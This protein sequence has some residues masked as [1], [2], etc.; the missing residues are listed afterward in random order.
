MDLVEN[1][2]FFHTLNIGKIA[3]QNVLENVL[4]RKISFLDYKKIKLK[5]SKIWDS[6]KAVSP[7]FWSKIGNF[8]IFFFKDNIG[9][10]NVLYDIL[11]RKN[12]FKGYKKKKLTKLKN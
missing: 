1:L 11:E 10:E 12:A 2:Q 7:C 6:S 4:E 8:Y 3:E 5:K 9:Q